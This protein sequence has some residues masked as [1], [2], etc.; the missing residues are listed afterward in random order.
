MKT[1]LRYRLFRAG[2]LPA[3]LRQAAAGSTV[4]AAEGISVKESVRG[5]RLPGARVSTGSSLRVG[6]LVVAPGRLLAAIGSRKI[7]DTGQQDAS[8]PRAMLEC[9]AD[10]LRLKLDIADI[11][12]GGA[13]SLEVHYRLVLDAPALGALSATGTAVALTGPEALLTPWHRSRAA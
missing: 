6:S 7:L 10:G 5:P 1:A 2:K 3:E 4:L 13:G 12:D 9:A 11:V 8:A